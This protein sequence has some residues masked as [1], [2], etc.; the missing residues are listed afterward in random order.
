MNTIIPYK[1]ALSTGAKHY[2]T[3]VPCKHGHTAL[4]YVATRH[5]VICSNERSYKYGLKDSSKQKAKANRYQRLYGVSVEIL[6][7]V[8]H[9]EICNVEFAKASKNAE[10]MCVDHNHTTGHYRGVLCNHCNRGLG[11][12]KD[13]PTLLER[14]ALYIRNKD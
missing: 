10:I 11:L 2:Y 1:L 9:C 7:N 14:A 12:F 13:D 4:R 6:E 3:G 8:L 5:C